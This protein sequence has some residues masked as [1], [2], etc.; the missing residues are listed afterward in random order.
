MALWRP[1]YGVFFQRQ[2]KQKNKQKTG[3][4]RMKQPLEIFAVKV[5][6]P[7]QHSL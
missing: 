1:E 5:N 2:N 7:L 4:D 3:L 6:A